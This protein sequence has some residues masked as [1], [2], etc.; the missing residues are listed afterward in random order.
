MAFS[1]RPIEKVI[2]EISNLGEFSEAKINTM[3]F[4]ART[5]ASEIEKFIIMLVVFWF[6]SYQA[7][8]LLAAFAVMTVRPTSGG[9]HSKTTLGCLLWTLSGFILAIF[10]LPYLVPLNS[11]VIMIAALFSILANVTLAPLRSEQR[12]KLADVT[13]DKNKKIILFI[14]NSMWFSLI[15]LNQNHVLA[16]AVMWILFLQ[17]FQLVAEYIRRLYQIKTKRKE[18]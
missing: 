17:S 5:F 12:E 8:Y 6:L 2:V 4:V 18:V 16:P 10:G 9:F 11:A 1:N 15:F 13:K 7:H 14:I 3:R